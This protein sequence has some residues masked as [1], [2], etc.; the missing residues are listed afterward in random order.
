M[1][2]DN[3]TLTWTK[4]DGESPASVTFNGVQIK[5]G[6]AK[7][8][9]T[10]YDF[11]GTYAASATVAADDYFIGSNKLWKST[12]ATTIKGTRAYI[13]AKTAAARI[14]GFAIDG[15]ETTAINGITISKDNAPIY[16]LNGQRV[17]KPAKGMY[18]KNGKK[19]VMK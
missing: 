1:S 16:N 3:K 15:E 12:G 8:A 19:V 14:A 4:A 9:G 6:D 11:V 10:N 13:K 18:V 5:T 17:A 2:T 7:V